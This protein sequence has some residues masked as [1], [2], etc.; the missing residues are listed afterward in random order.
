MDNTEE[1]NS[2]SLT[3]VDA[4]WEEAH[5]LKDLINDLVDVV[6]NT[7]QELSYQEAADFVFA[8]WDLPN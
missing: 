6:F 3:C 8:G 2:S 1:L 7:K 4:K 5:M